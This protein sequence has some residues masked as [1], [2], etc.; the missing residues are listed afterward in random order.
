M[1]PPSL[2]YTIWF[3]QRNGSTLL[4][5][6]M[7]QME[8]V[9]KPGEWLNIPVELSL[10][11]HYQVGA[12]G[13]LLPVLYQQGMGKN[14]VYGQKVSM[15]GGGMIDWLEE[16]A[17]ASGV[18]EGANAGEIWEAAFPNHRYI[19]LTR[20]NKVRQA[21]SWWKAIQTQ[22]WHRES[23]KEAIQV[24]PALMDSYDFAAIR[25]LLTEICLR[26]AAIEEFFLRGNSQP[27]TIVYEDFV[28]EYEQTIRDILSFLGQDQQSVEIPSP[29]LERL[30]D[31]VSEVWVQRFREEI[32]DGWSSQVW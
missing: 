24:P 28:R 15:H 25:H 10:S 26:E 17:Q 29:P 9:G 32:Q 22:E 11:Q 27:M 31:E 8:I 1:T 14:G 2:S 23:G 3:T 21:V 18:K 5:K 4:T 6:A 20:R 16:L 30:A 19:F 13:A 12:S 7:E